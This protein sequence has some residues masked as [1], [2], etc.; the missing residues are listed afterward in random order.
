MPKT[1]KYVI[2]SSSLRI[3][4][5]KHNIVIWRPPMQIGSD[6][7]LLNNGKSLLCLA[8]IESYPTYM[9]LAGVKRTFCVELV[10]GLAFLVDSW[11]HLMIRG[12]PRLKFWRFLIAKE[13][14]QQV[15]ISLF[16]CSFLLWYVI[17]VGIS[18]FLCS[19][20]LWY[21]IGVV[22]CSWG[23]MILSEFMVVPWLIAFSPDF[24]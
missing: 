10:M 14:E 7:S 13:R 22:L 24:V 12:L 18:L 9:F 8:T 21:V 6:P 5:D 16:L 11:A 3:W 19:F 4:K 20:L 17:S 2:S 15:G 1:H 23:N